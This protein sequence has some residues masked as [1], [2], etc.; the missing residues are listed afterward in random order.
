MCSRMAQ[1]ARRIL[2]DAGYGPFIEEREDTTAAQPGAAIAVF[3]DLADGMRLGADRAGAPRRAAERVG[4]AAARQLLQEL[5]SGATLGRCAADQFPLFAR[6]ADGRTQVR[7][8]A[9]TDH[10]RTGLWLAQL[11]GLGTSQLDG[12]SLTVDG[13]GPAPTAS[14]LSGCRGT[15]RVGVKP[16]D[17][18]GSGRR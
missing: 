9:V 12:R 11:F 3:A 1:A 7:L 2:V 4:A 8:A 16:C 17:E 13:G 10:V 15:R 5:A 18:S 14:Y 6:L